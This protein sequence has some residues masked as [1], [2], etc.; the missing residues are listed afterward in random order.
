MREQ[1][2]SR[3]FRNE[4][5]SPEL[6]WAI[7]ATVRP[8]GWAHQDGDTGPTVSDSG[9]A[10]VLVV[11]PTPIDC[12]VVKHLLAEG[13]VAAA[14]CL[15][16]LADLPLALAAVERGHQL[17]PGW[18]AP[19]AAALPQLSDRHVQL[20]QHLATETALRPL[21]E[22]IG[23]SLATVKRDI[24]ALS[25]RLGASNRAGLARIAIALG[26]PSRLPSPPP[27]RSL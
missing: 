3:A 6:R 18:V 27:Q 15:E 1:A 25:T 2:P 24:A 10:D 23:A 20:L 26:F 16:D 14:V 8:Y 22:R 11:R 21:G 13:R 9:V 12:A 17:T 4:V 5:D 19:T 7:D